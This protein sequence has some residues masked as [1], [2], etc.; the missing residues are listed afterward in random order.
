MVTARFRLYE[1]L[2][3][4]LP[5][6]RRDTAFDA[7][8]A[9]NATVKHMLEALGAPHTEIGPVRRNGRAASLD[10][11]LADGDLVEAWPLAPAPPPHSPPRFVADAHLGGLARF[12]RMA[13]FDTLYENGFADDAIETIASIEHRIVLTRDRELLKRSGVLRG[14]YVRALKPEPQLREVFLRYSLA[15]AVRPFSLCLNCNTPL[16]PIDKA[17]IADRLP[18]SV[19]ASHEHFQHCPSCGG[20]FWQGSHWR[21]MRALIASIAPGA[22]T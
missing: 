20:V 15:P 16:R 1:E 10:D 9:R 17:A 2:R 13:G 8:C 18:P 22:T 4:F 21:R 5:R 19:R 11:L 14:C 12:L 6:E 7:P 3:D